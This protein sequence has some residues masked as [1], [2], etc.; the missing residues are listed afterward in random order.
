MGSGTFR[1]KVEPPHQIKM[2]QQN[3]AINVDATGDLDSSAPTT[4]SNAQVS[5]IV[6]EAA[7]PEAATVLNAEETTLETA[8]SDVEEGWSASLFC[9]IPLN[10]CVF[11]A[12]RPT[13]SRRGSC[14]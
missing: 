14:R 3:E 10:P 6:S 2:A 7:A 1:T 11:A 8:T 13:A 5:G 9:H 12:S 4:N